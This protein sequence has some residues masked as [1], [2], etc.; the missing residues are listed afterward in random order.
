MYIELLLPGIVCNAHIDA[1]P[2][3]G[4]QIGTTVATVPAGGVAVG[5]GR[6][7]GGGGGGQRTPF[8]HLLLIVI[9]ITRSGTG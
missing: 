6:G 9:Q 5:G 3:A 8:G 7:R 2:L 4:F 1:A